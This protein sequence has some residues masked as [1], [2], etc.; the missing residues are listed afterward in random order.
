M[1]EWVDCVRA[2]PVVMVL[3]RIQDLASQ[4]SLVSAAGANLGTILTD[5]IH[6]HHTIIGQGTTMKSFPLSLYL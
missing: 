4:W 2:A 3:S 1:M 6:H 5:L